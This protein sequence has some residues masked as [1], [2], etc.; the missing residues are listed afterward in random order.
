MEIDTT[1]QFEWMI[2]MIV[3]GWGIKQH[4][5]HENP[6]EKFHGSIDDN[7]RAISLI[8]NPKNTIRAPNKLRTLID[9]IDEAFLSGPDGFPA[10]YRNPHNRNFEGRNGIP[11]QKGDLQDCYGRGIDAWINLAL[12]N[13]DTMLKDKGMKHFLK[14]AGKD[15][16]KLTFQNSLALATIAYTKFLEQEKNPKIQNA[17]KNIEQK[18]N[19]LYIINKTEN[20]KGFSNRHTYCVAAPTYALIEAGTISESG[21]SHKNAKESL[22]H[23]EKIMIVDGI[24]QP[25]GNDGFYTK[26]GQIA[27]YPQ[28]AIEAAWFTKTFAKAYQIFGNT[29]HK[30]LAETAA[31][32]FTG[33]NTSGKPLLG[34]NGEV[35]DGI[36]KGKRINKNTGAES[37]IAFLETAFA[38][39]KIN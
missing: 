18:L 2:A 9:Y 21:E 8:T 24:F 6:K 39:N 34:A 19:N 31:L 4:I 3:N 20:F 12:S 25:I 10:N 32:W 38:I 33:K 36:D 29:K 17:F 15:S 13:E 28:Q 27:R 30:T 1:S 22:E 11:D 37:V 7:A 14:H 5:N 23:L 26:G 35:Y 16:T